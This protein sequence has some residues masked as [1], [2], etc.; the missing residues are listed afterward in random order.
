MCIYSLDS[1]VRLTSFFFLP[2]LR[3]SLLPTLHPSLFPFHLLSFLQLCLPAALFKLALCIDIY[4]SLLIIFIG[5]QIPQCWLMRTALV[6]FQGSLEVVH[7]F[8]STFVT[9][10]LE[11]LNGHALIQSKTAYPF[12]ILGLIT[13]R[14]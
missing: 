9:Y 5:S 4:Y 10:I 1:L 7:L 2:T 11:S 6:D 3:P 13:E 12:R 14:I 8:I